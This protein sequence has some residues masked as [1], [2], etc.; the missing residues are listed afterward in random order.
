MEYSEGERE[1]KVEER[2]QRRLK[3]KMRGSR[4]DREE[5]DFFVKS[6][7]LNGPEIE[8]Y[9]ADE[10]LLQISVRDP[11]DQ[12]FVAT[13]RWKSNPNMRGVMVNV[14]ASS[15]LNCSLVMK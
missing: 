1:F 5:E 2:L 8:G 10:S 3:M 4:K 11:L 13:E 6:I 14:W 12:K 15:N 9:V 7:P